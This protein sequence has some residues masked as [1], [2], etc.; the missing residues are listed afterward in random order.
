MWVA[1]LIHWRQWA[2]N[3]I[4]CASSENTVERICN[5]NLVEVKQQHKAFLVLIS[6]LQCCLF[7]LP[8]GCNLCVPGLPKKPAHMHRGHVYRDGAGKGQRELGLKWNRNSIHV[9]CRPILIINW[10]DNFSF[11]HPHVNSL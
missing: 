8:S 9:C 3:S 11:N 4:A 1:L 2:N 6:P 10:P 7:F 5:T